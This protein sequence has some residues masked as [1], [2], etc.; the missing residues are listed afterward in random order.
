[1]HYHIV[2]I[3]GAGM[4]AIAHILLD[5]GHT[6]SGSDMVANRLT[7]SLAERGATLHVGH[8]PAHVT[9]AEALLATAAVK[10]EHPELVAAWSAGIPVLRR[11]DLWHEWSQQRTI[12]AVAGTHGK[13]TTTAMIAWVFAQAGHNPGFMIGSESV[14]LGI[15]ARWGDPAAP[16]IIEADEYDRVF[17]ALT[18]HTTV[19]TN[20]EWD[21]PDIYPT[22]E[23]YTQAFAEFARETE[24]VIVTCGDGSL[25]DW[26][27]RARASDIPFI[28]YGLEEPNDYRAIFP[29]NPHQTG[30]RW[31]Q[32]AYQQ[33]FR[34]RQTKDLPYVVHT[35]KSLQPADTDYRLRL[36]GLHNVRNA[37]A[38]IVVAQIFGLDSETTN[39]ALYD[40]RGTARRFELKGEEQ[41]ITVIDD[42]AHHPTEVRATLTAARTYFGPR[43]IVAYLQPHTYSRTE[44]LLNEWPAAFGNAD[45]ILI[46]DIYG[47][48]EAES[49]EAAR[50]LAQQLARQASKRNPAVQYVGDLESATKTACWLLRPGSVFLTM[51]AGDGD[52]VGEQVLEHF[53]TKH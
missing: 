3:A 48:R 50:A 49:A 13:T 41:G 14:N 20:V 51:G 21:H 46:G 52:Q 24:G 47:A 44:A 11:G 19:I 37:L 12:I 5:Q 7:E 35:S 32:G 15:N 27:Y 1:M 28:T 40:F 16:L 33:T 17:L 36:P 10:P 26:D 30:L 45:V 18:P 53:R 39:R 43:R 8:H 34:L 25:E 6:V 29:D 42:Y 2:G 4:N 22:R 31:Q 23:D 38:V 9:G